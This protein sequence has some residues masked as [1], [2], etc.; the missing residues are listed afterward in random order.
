MLIQKFKKYFTYI[1]FHFQIEM[2]IEP[3]YISLPVFV[4]HLFVWLRVED[5]L[6]FVPFLF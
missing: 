3:N 6:H 4:S 5:K 1:S 2:G